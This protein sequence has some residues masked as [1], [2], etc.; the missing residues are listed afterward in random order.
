METLERRHLVGALVVSA[1][2]ALAVLALVILG[3]APALAADAVTALADVERGAASGNVYILRDAITRAR[4]AVEAARNAE[5]GRALG[6]YE[7]ARSALGYSETTLASMPTLNAD[8]PTAVNYARQVE[9]LVAQYGSPFGPNAGA[10]RAEYQRANRV[11][12]G[13]YVQCG[14]DWQRIAERNAARDRVPVVGGPTAAPTPSAAPTCY[15]RPD[16][17]MVCG[18][19]PSR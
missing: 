18:N 2:A 3:A 13:L 15:T 7:S 10:I 16:G 4:P 1:L 17:V 14:K 19:R 5:A 12:F 8:C 11:L 9:P 6:A